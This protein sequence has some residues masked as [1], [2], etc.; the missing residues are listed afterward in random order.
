MRVF[1]T[2]LILIFS[3]Q[4]LIKADDVSDFEIEGISLGDSALKFFSK[5]DIEN[6]VKSYYKDKTY[7]PVEM[8]NYSFFNTYDGVD[9]DY[10]TN[11][12]DFIIHAISGVILY[13]DDNINECYD[14]LDSIVNDIRDILP[15]L[16]ETKKIVENHSVDKDS[17][18]TRVGFWGSNGLITVNCYDYSSKL[19]WTDH[20]AITINTNTFND[21]LMNAYGPS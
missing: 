9:F 19:G 11:D 20:L 18:I 21:F 17:T 1:L 16:Q 12:P 4:S 6:N 13:N 10:M 5:E 3:L 14:R 8:L 2:V 15:N 7:T